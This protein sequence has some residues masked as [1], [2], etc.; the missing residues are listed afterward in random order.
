MK[1]IVQRRSRTTLLAEV[2]CQLVVQAE[3]RIIEKVYFARANLK[4]HK[5][6]C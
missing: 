4:E 1:R 2:W 3:Q 5:Y 6:F